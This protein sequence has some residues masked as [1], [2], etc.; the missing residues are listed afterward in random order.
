MSPHL[1]VSLDVVDPSRPPA[2]IHA[3]R[4]ASLA[5]GGTC[6]SLTQLFTAL[7][8]PALA[9]ATMHAMWDGPPRTLAHG[10]ID[11]VPF[12]E[13]LATVPEPASLTDLTIE[14]D[15]DGGPRMCEWLIDLLAPL[16]SFHNMTHFSLTCPTV[17][18]V[19]RDDDFWLITGAWPRLRSFKLHRAFWD[20]CVDP[21]DEDDED[22]GND[23]IPCPTPQILECFREDCPDLGELR[24]PHLDV[25][26]DVPGL[27]TYV[28]R[29]KGHG[30]GELWFGRQEDEARA[31]E[32]ADLELED[33][34]AAEWARYML[35]L[36]SELNAES[37]R[38]CGWSEAAPGWMEV[39]ERVRGLQRKAGEASTPARGVTGMSRH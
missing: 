16:L 9:S 33:E 4:L 12:I 14:L 23:G 15:E 36:F 27:F 10:Y 17:G 11:Y 7:D 31:R 35:H 1:H 2:Q 6:P 39:F 30:L 34:K 22:E 8:A 25:H 3:P 29:R 13:A 37:L 21:D 38:Y 18:L 28:G 24:L 20:P 32:L 5:I 26:A 19:A